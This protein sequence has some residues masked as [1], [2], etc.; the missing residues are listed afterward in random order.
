MNI[1]Q[2][3]IYRDQDVKD[4]IDKKLNIN[5]IDILTKIEDK[6]KEKINYWK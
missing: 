1:D 5:N 3:N 6:Q 4:I 2:H